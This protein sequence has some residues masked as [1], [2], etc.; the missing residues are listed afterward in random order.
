MEVLC[1]LIS[2]G[3][4]DYNISQKAFNLC[5]PTKGGDQSWD[6]ELCSSVSGLASEYETPS[7]L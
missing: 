5:C 2:A 3:N 6:L 7:Y 1:I 4:M